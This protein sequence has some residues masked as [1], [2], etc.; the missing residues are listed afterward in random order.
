MLL[1]RGGEGPVG[2]PGG[3][4]TGGATRGERDQWG[5]QGGEG[6]VGPP[7]G[8]G[9]GGATRGRGTG[10][11]IRGERDRWG[12]QGGEGPVGPPGGR[13]TGGAT[14]G[15]RDWWGHQGGRGTGGATRGERDWWGHQGGEGPV[16]PPRGRGTGGATRGERG[17]WGHQG[18]EG[19]VG[20]PGGRGDCSLPPPTHR[21][22][23]SRPKV[24][25]KRLLVLAD[26]GQVLAH[27]F[28]HPPAAA[29]IPGRARWRTI[30]IIIAD[31]LIQNDPV[32]RP[33]GLS[34]PA[35]QSACASHGRHY[36]DS[37]GEIN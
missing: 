20:P 9:T 7:G 11:A 1:E 26:D 16:G 23:A 2:P 25:D 34:T 24:G 13:G 29:G 19:P 15:E 18:E 3:R 37:R 14:R 8:R 22:D 4:G 31:N 5:H 33:I 17:L 35:D 36:I 28:P 10:G 30:I 12:H 6:P 27:M 32:S 21:V